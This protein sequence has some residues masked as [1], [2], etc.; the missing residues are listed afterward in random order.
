MLPIL[1]TLTAL[2]VRG[3]V[4]DSWGG[5]AA[6]T[7]TALPVSFV[8]CVCVCVR[9]CVIQHLPVGLVAVIAMCER[10]CVLCVTVCV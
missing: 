2:G 6:G 9:V 1:V 10:R 4:P 3:V 8:I 7:P 5:W